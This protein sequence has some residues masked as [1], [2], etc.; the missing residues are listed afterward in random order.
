MLYN[1][2]QRMEIKTAVIGG[3]GVYDPDILY[4]IRDEKVTT[5]YGEV[6]L[7][8]GKYQ[9]RSVVF[10]NRHGEGHSIPPNMVNYRANI[11]ALNRLGVKN[12][13]ATAAVGSLNRH[14]QPGHLV[15]IDQFLDF[16]KFRQQTFFDGGAAGVVH[17]DM[18][19]PYCP[20][21]RTILSQ[22]AQNL[23][24]THHNGG[25]YVCTEGPRFETAAEIKMYRMLG[26]DL[27]GM[28]GVPEAPLAREAEICYATIA[29]VTNFA[30]G[31]SPD[32]L[33]HREVVD[34]MIQNGENIRKLLLE[35]ITMIGDDHECV[36][37][38]KA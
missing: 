22:A 14:M 4:G 38:S 18:T 35:A 1:G 27:V 32:R 8:I 13:L 5:P 21:L 23:G 29:M 15:F 33:S 20:G 26:G 7:K 17:T 24:L 31:I 34:T 9:D 36:C 28:T 16:T 6:E 25:V 37:Y 11:E 19:E 12:I 2:G 3:T 30:A 10:M